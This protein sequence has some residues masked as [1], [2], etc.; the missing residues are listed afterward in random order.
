MKKSESKSKTS[1]KKQG[2]LVILSAP[3]GCGKT[4]VLSR[5]LNRHPDWVRSVSVTTR[6]PRPE[7]DHGHD[8]QFVSPKEFEALKEKKEFLE[9]ARVFKH[10]YGTPRK[11]ILKAVE[12]G[13]PVILTVD[14]Q[15]HRSIRKEVA[16]APTPLFSLFILPPSI[17]VLRERLEKRST[18]S[19]KEIESR[20][21]MA[22]EEIKA[23]RE[24]DAT[25]INH[26]LDQTTH[27][28]EALISEFQKKLNLKEK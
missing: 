7:E 8:Y 25:V 28:I 15:G 24:Y 23:A 4:T 9:W 13:H 26:D 27:E 16:A 6:I 22:E 11:P 2:F 1:S 21:R 18:D 12:R 19:A 3:S 14:V 10:L 17:Q 5:L 20:I